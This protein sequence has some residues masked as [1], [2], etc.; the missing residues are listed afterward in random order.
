[1][2]ALALMGLLP[3]GATMSGA[4]RFEG[5]DLARLERGARCRACAATASR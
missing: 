4:I 1:M 5:R 3:D 2:T